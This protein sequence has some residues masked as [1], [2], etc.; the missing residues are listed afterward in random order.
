[1]KP[2]LGKL[3]T[4]FTKN[5]VALGALGAA[6]VAALAWKARTDKA[7]AAGDAP[8]SDVSQPAGTSK[9]P[10]YYTGT[11]AYDS[12]ATDIYNAIQPQL[13]ELRE[14]AGKIPV[15]GTPTT[16]VEA[17]VTEESA[18]SSSISSWYQQFLG[19]A[20]APSEIAFWNG[21]KSDLGSVRTA[22]AT[23]AEAQ[24]YKSGALG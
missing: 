19:R 15:P 11:G 24:L 14:L 12:T 9:T 5:R 16:P 20:A 2:N 4:L 8:A 7:G 1:M 13:E 21:Q 10:A 3:R 22:I 18:R 23:S 17:P 6:A